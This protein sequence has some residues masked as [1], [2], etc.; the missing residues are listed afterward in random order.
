M[1]N[2]KVSSTRR[3][4]KLLVALAAVPALLLPLQAGA[5]SASTPQ[6]HYALSYAFVD[7]GHGV[8]YARFWQAYPPTRGVFYY[9]CMTNKSGRPTVCEVVLTFTSPAYGAVNAD[10]RFCPQPSCNDNYVSGPITGGTGKGA[11]ATGTL[12]GYVTHKNNSGI[13]TLDFFTH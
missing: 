10:F 8:D 6:W 12:Q 4:T 9:T 11:G 7:V 1:F 5:A 2:R 13:V 3:F